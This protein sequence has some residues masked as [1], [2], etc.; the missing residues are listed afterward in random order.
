MAFL[1]GL[2]SAEQVAN[3]ILRQMGGVGRISAMAGASDFVFFDSDGGGGV[4]FKFKGNA[5]TGNKVRI[6]LTP[7]DLYDVSFSY[8]RG[9]TYKPIKDL[10]GV[11]ADQLKHVFETHTGLRL[12]L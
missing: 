3:T 5:K 9:M 8:V 6:T 4:M 1:G 12:S 11:Y 10:E 2:G 7:D